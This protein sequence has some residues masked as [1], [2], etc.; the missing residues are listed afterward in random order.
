MV[1]WASTMAGIF[2]FGGLQMIMLGVV[3]EYLWRIAVE[4]R[5]RP[6]YIVA[7]KVNLP[8]QDADA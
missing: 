3:G 7:D 1:G 8:D 5:S 6:L 2:F 4:V